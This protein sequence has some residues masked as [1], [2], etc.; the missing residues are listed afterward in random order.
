MRVSM[1]TVLTIPWAWA[2]GDTA[3]TLHTLQQHGYVPV[4]LTPDP[5][6][7]LLPQVLPQD[8]PLVF[9]L[10]AEGPGLSADTLRQVEVHARIPMAAGVD[11]LNISTA[12]AVA[13]YERRRGFLGV[14]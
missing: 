14:E 3:S 6:A 12:A 13:F 9:L 2:P 11:S 4:A 8:R 5:H 10:G 1:G 7:P